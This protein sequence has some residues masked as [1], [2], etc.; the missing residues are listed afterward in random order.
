[1]KALITLIAALAAS[2]ALADA[3]LP[4]PER[5]TACSPARNLCADSDPA[6]N[7]TRVTPQASGQEAWL[8]PGWHRWL[9]P[10]DD[11]ESVVVGYE[12]MNLVPVDVTLSEPVLLFYNRGRL[13]RTVTLD[14]SYRRTMV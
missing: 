2:P 11:G 14:Q 5:F 3:P 9:F 7:S 1:M 13:V 6:L 12:G 4:P 10:S 8:I